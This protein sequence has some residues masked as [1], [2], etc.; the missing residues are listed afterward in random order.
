ML[1]MLLRGLASDSVGAAVASGSLT[2]SVPHVAGSAAKPAR[3]AVLN[4]ASKDVWTA[5]CVVVDG[6]AAFGWRGRRGGS[7]GGW[8][9]PRPVSPTV[10][11]HVECVE[12]GGTAAVVED[13]L[14]VL[15]ACLQRPER[16]SLCLIKSDF[17]WIWSSKVAVLWAA[18]IWWRV[19]RI[20]LGGVVPPSTA[21]CSAISARLRAGSAKR[22]RSASTTS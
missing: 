15:P 8:W 22:R 17:L 20:T 14:L 21:C 11:V 3:S 12:S 7:A 18:V 9:C 2:L 4:C 6:A 19:A 1:P 10:L 13:E 16:S 5:A